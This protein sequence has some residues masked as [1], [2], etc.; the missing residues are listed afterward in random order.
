MQIQ[1]RTRYFLLGTGFVGGTILNRILQ[2]DSSAVVSALIRSDGQEV[3]LGKLGVRVVR[4]ELNDAEIIKKEVMQADVIIH[5][6]GNNHPASVQAILQGLRERKPVSRPAVYIHTSGGGVLSDEANGAFGPSRLYDDAAPD[7]IDSVPDDAPH[8]AVD[9][10]LRN[11]AKD[12]CKGHNARIG[13]MMPCLIY[14]IGSGPFNRLSIQVPTLVKRS[15]KETRPVV[16]GK[17]L[18]VWSNVHVEDLATAYLMVASALRQD[19]IPDSTTN[20]YYNVDNGRPALWITLTNGIARSLQLRDLLH[21][22]TPLELKETARLWSSNAVVRSSRL[23]K[24]GFVA[25]EGDVVDSID[26]EVEALL[27]NQANAQ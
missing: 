24:L 10:I 3:A 14:G 13:I 21:S 20:P 18:A 22:I 27:A 15:I 23:I 17:G 25:K 4:G 19:A 2:T 16:Y 11:F 8:R 12:E 9:L 6:A 5:S 7:D 26:S 1:E